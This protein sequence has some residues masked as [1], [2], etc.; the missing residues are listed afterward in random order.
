MHALLASVIYALRRR[1][2][3]GD[4]RPG[5]GLGRMLVDE[6]M[7]GI[8][9]AAH[10]VKMVAATVV[11]VGLGIALGPTTPGPVLGAGWRL[12]LSVVTG[13]FAISVAHALLQRRGRDPDDPLVAVR[14]LVATVALLL[15]TTLVLAY[16]LAVITGSTPSPD[17][18][19]L[20]VSL[21]IDMPLLVGGGLL[22]AGVIAAGIGNR[23]AVPGALLFLGLGMPLGTDGLRLVDL[24]DAGLVQSVSIAAL[25]V[26]LFD[27]GVNTEAKQLRAGAGPGL[28]LATVGVAITAGVVALG[29]IWLLGVEAR[30]AWLLG[31]IVSSTDAAAVF[32]LLRRVPLADRLASILKIESGANDPVAILLTIGLLAAWDTPPTAAA[33]LGFGALQM[34]GGIVVGAVCGW[35]GAL[36]LR[37]VELGSTGLYP[38]LALAVAALTYGL[39]V[40]AGAS[41]FMAVY[42]AG[43]VVASDAPRRRGSI[44]SFLAAL[45]GAAEVG[46]FLLLGL[47]VNPTDLVGVG[48]TAFG[49][50]ALLVAVGRPLACAITLVWFDLTPREVAAVAVLGLRGAVPIVLATLAL[51]AGIAEADLIFN[52]VFF[53]VLTSTVI[54]GG[55]ARPLLRRLGLQQP[56]RPGRAVAEALPLEDVEVDII[57]MTVDGSSPLADAELRTCAP[58]EGMLV[59]TIVRDDAVVIPSGSTRLRSGDV[60]IIATTDRRSGMATVEG[61]VHPVRAEHPSRSLSRPPKV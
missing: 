41:G 5:P 35:L 15:S 49:L 31:A 4:R 42:L 44:R 37:R 26:I 40:A 27:G 33:W 28:A 45:A 21:P 2:P 43:I 3:D 12:G 20:S 18:P 19:T 13:F 7:W 8:R 16:L 30:V 25:V 52:L 58:P 36:L 38:V 48:L 24:S 56:E 51:S 50:T 14:V 1:T 55:A 11:A 9:Q 10:P 53:V 17:G 60:L 54:Q 6:L 39:A 59:A 47:L 61:W 34:I 23:L 29:S 57:E 46:L 22:A 32:S